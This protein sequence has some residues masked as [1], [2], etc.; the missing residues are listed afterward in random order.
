MPSRY[1]WILIAALGLP[2]VAGAQRYPNQNRTDPNTMHRDREPAKADTR[3]AVQD[4]YAALEHELPS[5]KTDLGLREPQLNAWSLF[6]RDVR[7]AAELERTRRKHLMALRESGDKPPT[8]PT[9]ISTL[10]EE[11]RLRAEA[12][13]DLK[14]HFDALYAALDESQRKT[15]DKRVVLSQTDP[16]GR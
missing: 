16:L 5:L 8:A 15:V 6:E 11:D 9:V 10:A 12:T 2:L 14:R 13:A 3:L 1:A 4:P 7:D